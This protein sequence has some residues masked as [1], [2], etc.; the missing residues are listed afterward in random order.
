[1]TERR[2]IVAIDGPSGTGKSSVSKEVARRL[3]IGY[4]DTGAM[5]RALA[6]WCR[7]SGIE[8]T[9]Q[10]AVARAARTLP[11]VMGTTPDD[12]RVTV[13]GIAIDQDIRRSDISEVVS[14]VATNLDVRA[15]MKRRQQQ[16]IRSICDATGGVVAEGRDITTVVAPYAEARILMTASESVRMARRSKE[17]AVN[18]EAT[19]AQIVDRDAKD[20]T[21]AQ[22]QTA[23]DGVV[24]VDTSE[25][26]FEQSVEAVLAAIGSKADGYGASVATGEM[27]D[28]HWQQELMEAMPGPWRRRLPPAGRRF[29]AV[30]TRALFSARV[31]HV[32]RVPESGAVVLVCDEAALVDG[33]VIFSVAP[34]T[35]RFLVDRAHFAGPAGV[36][37]RAFGQVPVGHD[38]ADRNS[39]RDAVEVLAAGGVV[40]VL[41]D[42]DRG[43]GAAE[44]AADSAARLAL[45]TRAL[46][47]PVVVTGSHGPG[48]DPHG[49]PRP[50]ARITVSFGRPFELETPTG[51]PGEER[52]RIAMEHLRSM[53]AEHARET[54]G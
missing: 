31:E 32:E 26:D 33:P 4:L 9:D 38:P 1:M 51:V 18:A 54:Y 13:D 28:V 5:Y 36:L 47:V 42:A 52:L 15:I 49:W 12:P 3:G 22:F 11:L 45:Q 7:H 17:L 27:F 29:G 6:W 46:V 48:G 24:T 8:L 30:A 43:S 21:V 25:L 37:L 40:G 50:R 2:L 16:L 39:L 19:R 10:Q 20:A 35:V 53:L 34:R 14:L 23:A 44:E 41:P